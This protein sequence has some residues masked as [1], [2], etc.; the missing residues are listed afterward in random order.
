MVRTRIQ[1]TEEQARKVRRIAQEEGVSMGAIIRPWIDRGLAERHPARSELWERALDRLTGEG[2]PTGL[3]DVISFLV[4]EDR[5]IEAAFSFDSDIE[6]VGF[7][8][9]PDPG[10]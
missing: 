2:N 7:R 1:L 5:G 3:V 9:I 4:M 6:A 8:Q 10:A